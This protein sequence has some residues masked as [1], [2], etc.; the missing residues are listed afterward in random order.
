MMVL[1][2]IAIDTLMM[3]RSIYYS[4]DVVDVDYSVDF[5]V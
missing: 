3:K 1:N 5:V 4:I 2:L